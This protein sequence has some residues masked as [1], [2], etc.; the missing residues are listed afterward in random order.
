MANIGTPVILTQ[1][2]TGERLNLYAEYTKNVKESMP[3]A[4]ADFLGV[5]V[6]YLGSTTT[7]F[8]TAHAYTCIHNGDGYAWADVTPAVS[9]NPTPMVSKVTFVTTEDTGATVVLTREILGLL[10]DDPEYDIIDESGYNI[11]ADARISRRWTDAG[12]EIT[13]LGGWPAGTYTAKNN[14]AD[15]YSRAEID[16]RF[17]V[18]LAKLNLI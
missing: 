4:S 10:V 2:G 3:S 13:F 14:L 6:L 7:D 5:S 15:I 16:A 12:Y 18:I 1:M 11:T 9:T 8:T 17:S